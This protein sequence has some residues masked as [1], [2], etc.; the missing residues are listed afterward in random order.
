MNAKTTYTINNVN[1]KFWINMDWFVIIDCY[2][3]NYTFFSENTNGI[4]KE[5]F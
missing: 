4:I 3:K 5:S 2:C 1:I